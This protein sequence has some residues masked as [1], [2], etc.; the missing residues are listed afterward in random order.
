MIYALVE[1]RTVG[2]QEQNKHSWKRDTGGMDWG[3]TERG[4]DSGN[5]FKVQLADFFVYLNSNLSVGVYRP[6]LSRFGGQECWGVL[7]T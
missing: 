5:G 4:L 7:R 2:D 3:G 6:I 1:R